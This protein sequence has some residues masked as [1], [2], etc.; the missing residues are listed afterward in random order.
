[1]ITQITWQ[2][3]PTS[4]YIKAKIWLIA[5]VDEGDFIP[6]IGALNEAIKLRGKEQQ[7]VV[8]FMLQNQ[9]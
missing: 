9:F 3:C 6:E 8:T 2:N 4:E 1:M 5:G 7:Q